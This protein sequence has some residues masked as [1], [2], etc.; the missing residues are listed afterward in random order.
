[1]PSADEDHRM[2]LK[3]LENTSKGTLSLGYLVKTN[4]LESQYQVWGFE[5]KIFSK[6]LLCHL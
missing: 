2:W 1:M 5:D 6:L 3:A 4:N